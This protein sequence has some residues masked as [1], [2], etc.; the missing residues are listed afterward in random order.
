MKQSGKYKSVLAHIDK[1]EFINPPVLISLEN[2]MNSRTKHGAFVKNKMHFKF[3][4]VR[5]TGHRPML[6]I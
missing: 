1:S 5:K 2:Q 3:M 6:Q 4:R